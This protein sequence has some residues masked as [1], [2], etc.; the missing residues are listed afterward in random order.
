MEDE[1]K[2][3]TFS[4]A[5]GNRRRRTLKDLQNTENK[6]EDRNRWKGCK[7]D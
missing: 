3:L 2:I 4:Q 6:V 5:E 1:S 7:A